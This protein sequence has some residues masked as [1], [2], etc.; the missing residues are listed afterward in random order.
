M[1]NDTVLFTL[2]GEPMVARLAPT[3]GSPYPTFPSF[4]LDFQ[5]RT[6]RLVRGRT[7]VPVPE[8]IHFERSDQWLGVPF[9]VVRAVD[10]LVPPDD[11][12]Y[13]VHG[14][15]VEATEEQRQRLET[16]SINVLVE[17][18]KITDDGADTLFLQPAV[19]GETALGRQLECQ[20]GYY[21]WAREGEMVPIVE[22]AFDVLAKT[23]PAARRSVL[24][25]GDSRIGNIIFRDFEPVAVL[26]WEMATVG[27]PEVDL[28]WMTFI[29]AFSQWLADYFGS[30]GL[31][32]MFDQHR[33]VTTYE[34]LAGT[35][36]EGLT[37]FETF[38]ALRY[39]VISIRQ[40]FRGVAYGLQ[41]PP[42][43]PNQ[44]VMGRHL[45]KNLLKELSR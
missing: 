43:R 3:P 2:S 18:H 36:I 10:G 34:R 22:Q 23:M 7:A 42:A 4:D 5:D 39:A 44:R 13:V 14:W 45:L 6:M 25:W 33:A 29:H 35:K 15:V 24:N 9:L 16:S 19:P 21:E 27:P 37:W 17:L 38:A 26:D 31:P 41:A 32:D 1:A 11:P 30:P 20:R 8:V 12:P 40:S 28:A